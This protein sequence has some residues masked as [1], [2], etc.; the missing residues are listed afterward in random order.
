MNSAYALTVWWISHNWLIFSI[1]SQAGGHFTPTSRPCLEWHSKPHL[2]SN[3][4]AFLSYY[5]YTIRLNVQ[6]QS[7]IRQMRIGTLWQYCRNGK[8]LAD[9]T[10][11]WQRARSIRD[12]LSVPFRGSSADE[13]RSLYN[14][15]SCDWFR[16]EINM[17]CCVILNFLISWTQIS[18]NVTRFYLL[19]GV[20]ITAY[21]QAPRQC[22]V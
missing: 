16:I 15:I 2:L 6:S 5:F 18:T 12:C 13:T 22:Y 7:F 17:L 11:T 9:R 20:D 8:V 19:N 10:Y 1:N 21:I 4:V 3:Y 14:I